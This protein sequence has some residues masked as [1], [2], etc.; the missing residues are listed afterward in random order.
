MKFNRNTSLDAAALDVISKGEKFKFPKIFF[1]LHNKNLDMSITH[2]Y[3]YHIERD[4][5]N[6]ITDNILVEFALPEGY[7]RDWILQHKD[8]LEI[9]IGIT[10]YEKKDATNS[11]LKPVTVINRYKFIPLLKGDNTL[12]PQTQNM[13]DSELNKHKLKKVVGQCISPLILILKSTYISGIYHNLTL[14]KLYKA[15]M[16][17]YLNKLTIFG[18]NLNYKLFPY[19]FDNTRTY[20]NV[21][22]KSGTKLIKLA[23]YL[24]NDSYGLYMDGGNTYFTNINIERKNDLYYIYTYPLY[25]KDRYM[26][27]TTHPVLDLI[28]TTEK[29]LGNNDVSFYYNLGHYK[30]VVTHVETINALEQEK[31]NTATGLRLV[32]PYNITNETTYSPTRCEKAEYEPDKN[33]LDAQLDVKLNNFKN[34]QITN[35]D[36]NIF[37]HLGIFNKYQ[38]TLLK[39]K[40]PK[41]NIDHLYPGMPVSYILP[42]KGTIRLMTG[43]LQRVTATYYLQKK[44]NEVE[45]IVSLR[46][47]D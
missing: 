8:N 16:A 41:S 27:D 13:Q 6:N 33:Y 20:T 22:I 39:I 5:N 45:I 25:S 26:N 37:R 31:Y 19:T 35:M 12:D 29:H 44:T 17:K 4:Y 10:Y 24:Q 2:A 3:K 23:D 21:T 46:H 40:I 14:E 30:V 43:V 1:I 47:Q 9:S 15:L 34:L 11:V 38:S 32:L 18:N 28:S 7:Y 42:Y 36:H